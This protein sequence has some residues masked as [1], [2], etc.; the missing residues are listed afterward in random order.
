MKSKTLSVYT[1][2]ISP[3]DRIIGLV[4]ELKKRLEKHL[5][6]NYGSVN[7]LAHVTLILFV[8]Y[9]DD[10]PV[11]LDEFKRVLAGIAPLE[12]GFSGFGDFSK[13]HPCTFFVKPDD[14]SKDE[15]VACCQTIGLNF[16]KFIKQRFTDR[17]DIKGRVQPHMTI[18]RDLIF[19]EISLSYSLFTEDFNEH[20][21]CNSFVIRKFNPGKG[22]YEIIDTIP[23]L[24]NE[25]MV[26]Q[27]MRLF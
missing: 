6:R 5:G 18:G 20:F 11:I 7:S 14:S 26:G 4:T 10:Y 3:D 27:Q 19:E 2:A 13:S 1:L 12:I 9:E 17:W 15:I 16:H 24:G 25:Y 23:L 8:A 21:T 22:Q